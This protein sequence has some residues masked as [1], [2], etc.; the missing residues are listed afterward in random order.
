MFE[1]LTLGAMAL[2]LGGPAL[3]IADRVKRRNFESNEML[4]T[5][6][7]PLARAHGLTFV[8]GQYQFAESIQASVVGV[9][10]GHRLILDTYYKVEDQDKVHL[11]TRLTMG[12]NRDMV[13]DR[14]AAVKPV[15]AQEVVTQLTMSDLPSSQW[16]IRTRGK[17]RELYYE[18]RGIET[19][20]GYL[21]LVLDTMASRAESHARLLELGGEAVETLTGLSKITVDSALRNMALE[22]LRG[23]AEDTGQRLAHRL[24]NLICPR[25]LSR[26]QA[27]SINLSWF[28]NLTYYGCRLC[29]QSRE[30][31][32]GQIFAVLNSRLN[33]ELVE[34]GGILHVN[35]LVRRTLFDFDAV[36]I[37]RA[38]DEAV[39][40]FAVQV[41]N[42]TDPFR[43]PRYRNMRC[44]VA[45]N[46]KLSHNTL[47]VLR[48][49]FGRLEVIKL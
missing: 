31:K 41:G 16:E 30:Y 4:L 33:E 11:F 3:W 24:D 42:D 39:E 7:R 38:S 8:P 35:W 47:R 20:T 45:A 6:W 1:L 10:R 28:E 21:Q 9:Y 43:R 46:A 5:L 18:Q 12:V 32:Q 15:T 34:R 22:L 23:I 17:G 40:R 2:L 37:A 49:T 36:A 44:V 27:Q 19:N 25:C 29:H 48:R 14:S 13:V 26:F